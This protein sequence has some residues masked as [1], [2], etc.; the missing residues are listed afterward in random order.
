[1]IAYD[2]SGS[3]WFRLA[4]RKEPLLGFPMITLFQ[5]CTWLREGFTEALSSLFQDIIKILY[6][7]EE[8][9]YLQNR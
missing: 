7:G 9:H 6:F 5:L 4:G 3:E 2:V 8:L 1:M